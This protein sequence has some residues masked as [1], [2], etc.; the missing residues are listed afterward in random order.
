MKEGKTA[1]ILVSSDPLFD[2]RAKKIKA[3]L[4]QMGY[5]AKICG[6]FRFDQ[7]GNSDDIRWEMKNPKGPRFYAE[8]GRKMIGFIEASPPT[9]VWACDPDT[10]WAASW[11]KKSHPFF[12]GLR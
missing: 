7:A 6:V 11:A 4:I 9:L 10:L 12:F 1:L 2:Q 8:L 3:S 5:S